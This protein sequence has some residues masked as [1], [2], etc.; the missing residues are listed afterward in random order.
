MSGRPWYKRYGADFV[1]GCLGLTLE[2][3]GAY[4]LCLDLIYDRGGPIP[5]DARWLAGVCGVS[6][7]KWSA[8]RGRLIDAGKLVETGGRLSNTRA[9]KE[10]ETAAKT[11]QKLAESGA[12]GGFNRAVNA[13]SSINNNDL[14]EASLKHTRINQ[15]PDAREDISDTDVSVSPPASLEIS[16]AFQFYNV[17]ADKVGWPKADRLT[18]TRKSGLKA[19]LADCGGSA[20]W[21]AALERAGASSFLSG[22]NDRGWKPNIDFFLQAKSFTKLLEGAYDRTVQPRASPSWAPVD[23]KAALE[24]AMAK[25]GIQT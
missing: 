15:K 24:R 18:A 22:D 14:D 25:A 5:D 9:E 6:V 23:T 16:E 19:R 4:S 3:K 7:R 2:E 1:H 17:V 12:K 13:A 11:S 20:G 8:L 21:R 10:I